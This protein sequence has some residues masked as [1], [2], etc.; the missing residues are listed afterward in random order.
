MSTQLIS[1]KKEPDKNIGKDSLIIARTGMFLPI[2]ASSLLVVLNHK[3]TLKTDKLITLMVNAKTP[4]YSPDLLAIISAIAANPKI[5]KFL[6]KEKNFIFLIA[7]NASAFMCK[8][9]KGIMAK[10]R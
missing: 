5:E 7:L 2:G 1:K 10:I 3:K 9:E 6:K 4:I 8:T